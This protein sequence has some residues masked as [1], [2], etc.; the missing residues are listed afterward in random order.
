VPASRLERVHRD[1][2]LSPLDLQPADLAR[3]ELARERPPG[4]LG[5]ERGDAVLAGEALQ[6]RRE[7]HHVA[8]GRVFQLVARADVAECDEAG[9]DAD[10]DRKGERPLGPPVEV[11]ERPPDIDRGGAGVVGVFPAGQ[12]ENREQRVA[13]ERV[14]K[15]IVPDDDLRHGREV[16]IE[17]VQELVRRKLLIDLGER[18]HVHEKQGGDDVL[19]A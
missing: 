8:D 17:L 10:A 1:E 13:D 6:P 11:G 12:A 7:V 19:P 14:D 18:P 15:P 4:A 16:R 5:D 2:L 3:F 9:V